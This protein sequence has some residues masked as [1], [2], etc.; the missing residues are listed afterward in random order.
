M[1]ISVSV[2]DANRSV[3]VYLI[4]SKIEQNL[5]C[6]FTH[7]LSIRQKRATGKKL[8]KWEQDYIRDNK[9]VVLLKNKLTE[10]EKRE[11]EEDEKAL[12]EL[13]G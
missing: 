9:D 2:H 3:F 10:Q 11:R 7:I 12:K 8:E 13:L 1:D 4:L 5:K 6:T